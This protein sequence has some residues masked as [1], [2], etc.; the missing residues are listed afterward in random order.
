M[1]LEASH[2]VPP[3]FPLRNLQRSVQPIRMAAVLY[4]QL[5]SGAW[6]QR[7][8]S[9]K[10][11]KPSTLS[12]SIGECP[13]C[14][15]ASMPLCKSSS[16]RSTKISLQIDI[17]FTI[18]EFCS[19]GLAQSY[20]TECNYYCFNSYLKTMPSDSGCHMQT[21][22]IVAV[23]IACITWS[24]TKHVNKLNIQVQTG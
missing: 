23:A 17:I 11:S 7:V 21:Y 22:I 19:I 3:S 2:P 24:I 18:A 1:R 10:S 20:S 8:S 13:L 9:T 12:P 4:L 6:A 15:S 14:Y 5:L 16:M